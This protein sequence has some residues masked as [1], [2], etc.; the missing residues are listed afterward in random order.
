MARVMASPCRKEHLFKALE[1]FVV[2]SLSAKCPTLCNPMDYSPPGSSAHGISQARILEL[3][4]ISFSKGSS[5]TRDQTCLSCIG[6]QILN[7][8][9]SHQGSPREE[10]ITCFKG[11]LCAA[12]WAGRCVLR[13]SFGVMLLQSEQT[14]QVPMD[15]GLQPFSVKG[16]SVDILGVEGHT[17]PVAA[18]GFHV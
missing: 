10:S 3:V 12:P 13:V 15:Q 7:L 18:T 11:P 9:L 6:R 14:E 5:Q 16:Q 17:V 8:Q 4:A 2:Q 1:E